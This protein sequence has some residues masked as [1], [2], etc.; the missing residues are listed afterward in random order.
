MAFLIYI[1]GLVDGLRCV[2]SGLMLFSAIGSGICLIGKTISKGI[3]EGVLSS[4]ER[5]YR[6]GLAKDEWGGYLKAWTS[7]FKIA[8]PLLI[9][10]AAVRD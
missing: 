4:D 2:M 6:G 8:L 9:L 10:S 7:G 5:S 3:Y 1:I